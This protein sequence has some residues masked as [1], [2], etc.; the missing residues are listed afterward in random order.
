M[1]V[2]RI[3]IN[4]VRLVGHMMIPNLGYKKDTFLEPSLISN[5]LT[6][7]TL[8]ILPL[9]CLPP[10]VQTGKLVVNPTWVLLCHHRPMDPSPGPAASLGKH[11][12][13]SKSIGC[14]K[15]RRCPGLTFNR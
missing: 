4:G 14:L 13:Y 3:M 8:P 12:N 5:F 10:V 1:E 7:I 6:D 2:D 11:L 15:E 9:L